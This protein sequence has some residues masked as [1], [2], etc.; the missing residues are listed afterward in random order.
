MRQTDAQ[1]KLVGHK[2]PEAYYFPLQYNQLEN[3]FP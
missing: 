3:N 1:A 2:A